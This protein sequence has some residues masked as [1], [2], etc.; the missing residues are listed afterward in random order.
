MTDIRNHSYSNM[1]FKDPEII[2]E[3]FQH[4][5]RGQKFDTLIGTGLSGALVVPTLARALGL[6]WAIIR[7]PNDGSHTYAKFEGE[8][9]QRWVFVDDFVS[10]GATRRRVQEAVEDI[11]QQYGART[12]YVGTYEYE[13]SRFRDASWEI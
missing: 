9:G 11:A 6:K 3:D 13:K 2:L 1:A 8:I 10:S 5:T 4:E 7:K 12:R